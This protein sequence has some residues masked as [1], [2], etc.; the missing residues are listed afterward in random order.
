MLDHRWT[1]QVIVYRSMDCNGVKADPWSDGGT[2]LMPS[3]NP[4]LENGMLKTGYRGKVMVE[5][6]SNKW[7]DNGLI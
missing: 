5:S 6:S 3:G 2:K 4:L 7:I 1:S